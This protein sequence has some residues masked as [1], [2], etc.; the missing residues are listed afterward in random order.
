VASTLNE[1]AARSRTGIIIDE[2]QLPIRKEVREAC[3]ILGLDP[4]YV[5][6]EGKMVAAVAPKD[7]EKVLQAMKKNPLGAAAAIIGE[8]T[9]LNAGKVMMKTPIGTTRI[10]DMMSGEQLPRIC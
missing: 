6:N 9:N 7:A 3:E 4:L 10:V 5:A 8:V 2:D 1:F